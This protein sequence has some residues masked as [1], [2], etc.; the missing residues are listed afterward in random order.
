ML[1]FTQRRLEAERHPVVLDPSQ[2]AE[3]AGE[4]QG[5]A[6]VTITVEGRDLY[7]VVGE[8]QRFRVTPLGED[9]FEVEGRPEPVR[10][11]RDAS[12]AVVA[13]EVL[14]SGQPARFTRVR[15]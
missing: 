10:V 13:L 5:E 2:L 11:A 9:Y 12:G 6:P 8:N 3:L 7:L 1:G 15:R 14:T 4:Y